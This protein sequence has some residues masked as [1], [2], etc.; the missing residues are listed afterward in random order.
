MLQVHGQSYSSMAAGGSRLT[1]SMRQVAAMLAR[2]HGL[3]IR[4]A[5]SF[6]RVHSPSDL[7]AL[8]M[9]SISS[10]KMTDGCITPA[11]A[12][13]VFTCSNSSSGGKIVR[14]Q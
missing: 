7:R 5:A 6:A 3:G 11:T 8:R 4:T 9:E 1:D 14:L 13:N 10:M 2:P 12:N